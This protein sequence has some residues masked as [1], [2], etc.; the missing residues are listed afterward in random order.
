MG[1]IAHEIKDSW[2]EREREKESETE[3]EIPMKAGG[4][5]FLQKSGWEEQEGV[6]WVFDFVRGRKR[7]SLSLT[8]KFSLMNE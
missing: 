8:R 6:T 4:S 1:I 2:S 3:N 5:V 7:R